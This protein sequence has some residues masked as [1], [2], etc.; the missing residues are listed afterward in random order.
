MCVCV[1]TGAHE[2]Q[3]KALNPLEW[4]LQAVMRLPTWLL[5]TEL[6]SSAEAEN[7]LSC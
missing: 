3:K 6:Y 7:T 4:N 1:H 5:E 2:D